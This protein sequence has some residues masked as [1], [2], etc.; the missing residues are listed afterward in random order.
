MAGASVASLPQNFRGRENEIID[1]CQGPGD[2]SMAGVL[3][4]CSM[5]LR[6]AG[7]RVPAC[8]V[9]GQAL[10][11]LRGITAHVHQPRPGGKPSRPRPQ[12]FAFIPRSL[13]RASLRA[14]RQAPHTL[15]P[16]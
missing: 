14:K 8:P 6:C 7:G 3:K 11:G 2:V 16:C 15:I 10:K 5:A 4:A 1:K 9:A 12:A 13:A